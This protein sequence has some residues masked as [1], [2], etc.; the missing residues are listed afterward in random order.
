MESQIIFTDSSGAAAAEEI[1]DKSYIDNPDLV[2]LF[3]TTAEVQAHGVE[4]VIAGL[5]YDAPVVGVSVGGVATHES[6]GFEVLGIAA[7]L[8][9][10]VEFETERIEDAWSVE[11]GIKDRISAHEGTVMSF[12]AGARSAKGGYG[13]R[14]AQKLARR[15][16]SNDSFGQRKNVIN[17][18]EKRLEK[19]RI[20]YPNLF[21]ARLSVGL[22]TNIVNFDSVD[23]YEFLDGYE[24]WNSEV[25]RGKSAVLVYMEEELE[26][27]T[28]FNVWDSIESDRNVET[29]E[30]LQMEGNIIYGLGDEL[31]TDIKERH[32]IGEKIGDGGFS[33]YLAV[34]QGDRAY[35]IP[36]S[37][38]LGAI[39]TYL[40]LDRDATSH[41]LRAPDFSRYADSYR[42]MLE[43]IQGT[44]HISINPPQLGYFENKLNR[45][46]EITEDELDK[47]IVTIDNAHRDYYAP[48]FNSPGYVEY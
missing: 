2:A 37:S 47:F 10:D 22:D 7:V 40:E 19:D 36:F 32:P 17:R 12:E 4:E 16:V 23:S 34:E 5:D 46:I 30:G 25:T 38:D 14:L 28:A 26:K 44:P 6:D 33:Y 45:V 18:I 24:I 1:L 27:G 43:D 39:L 35:S 3:P 41:I 29:F 42:A 8:F 31:L 13:W 20:G 11:P 48:D 9:R 15:V 21:R